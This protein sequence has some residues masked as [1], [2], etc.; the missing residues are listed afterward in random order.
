[1]NHKL[2]KSKDLNEIIENENT[3]VLPKIYKLKVN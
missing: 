1:M 2:H 3:S